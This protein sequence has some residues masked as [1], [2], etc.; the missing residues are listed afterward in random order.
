MKKLLVI[1]SLLLAISSCS[2]QTEKVKLNFA[3]EGEK[4]NVGN[5]VKVKVT[6]LDKRSEKSDVLGNKKYCNGRKIN[7]ASEENLTNFLK[8]TISKDLARKGFKAGSD[9]TMEVSIEELKYKSR[10]GFIGKSKGEISV[11][12]KIKDANQTVKLTKNFSLSLN[13]KT[14]IISL[15]KTDEKLLNEM[16]DE[17]INNIIHDEALFK[18]LKGE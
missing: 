9:R 1:S 10:C 17:V 4:I 14:F 3:F 6:V 12:V 8:E 16:I 5:N 11:M 18:A 7:I 2:Y 13:N 15:A